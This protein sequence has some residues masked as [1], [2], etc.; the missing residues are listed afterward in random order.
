MRAGALKT[1]IKIYSKTHTTNAMN[2]S[3]PSYALSVTLHAQ[4]KPLKVETA[5]TL[6]DKIG[7]ALYC[8]FII[9]YISG[10]TGANI[11]KDDVGD[12][13][14]IQEPIQQ[15]YSRRML[16]ITGKKREHPPLVLS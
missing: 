7:D 2:E 8:N 15:D 16:I 1:L 4:K 6:G 3:V 9:R 14:D 5:L 10:I 12:W 11:I 13:Y